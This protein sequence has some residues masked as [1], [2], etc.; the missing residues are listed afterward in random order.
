MYPY[1][2]F[3]LAQAN[4]AVLKVA[5]LTSRA[6]GRIEEVQLAY[7]SKDPGSTERMEDEMQSILIGWQEAILKL[8]GEPKGV[9]TVDFRSPDPNV[10]WCW[11]VDESEIC[12]RHFT[13]ETFKDRCSL[14]KSERTWPASN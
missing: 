5:T 13:W 11:T 2:I 4:R 14:A 8:G 1:R 3:T 6:Q 12:H 10:L 7:N 9:F